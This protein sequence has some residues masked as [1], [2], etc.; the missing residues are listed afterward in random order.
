M[1]AGPGSTDQHAVLR[2]WRWLKASEAQ[3]VG[4]PS[5]LAYAISREAF[6]QRLITVIQAIERGTISRVATRQRVA[7]QFPMSVRSLYNYL[8]AV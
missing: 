7:N 2:V 8:A 6:E 5:E 4:R 1:I 3:A